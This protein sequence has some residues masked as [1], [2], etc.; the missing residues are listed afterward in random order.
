M[1]PLEYCVSVLCIFKFFYID[2]GFSLLKKSKDIIR[3]LAEP[4]TENKDGDTL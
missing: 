4:L 1:K 3:V 2:V